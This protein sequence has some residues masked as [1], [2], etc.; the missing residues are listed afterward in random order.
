MSYTPKKTPLDLHAEKFIRDYPGGAYKSTTTA[1]KKR[2]IVKRVR[3]PRP[4]GHKRVI[5]R[6]AAGRKPK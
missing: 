3:S 5:K 1:S 2:S 4:M 6:G